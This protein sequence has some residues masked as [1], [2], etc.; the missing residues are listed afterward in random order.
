LLKG[1]QIGI[2]ATTLEANAA[3]RSIVRRDSGESYEEFLKGLAHE[4]GIDASHPLGL[5][6]MSGCGRKTSGVLSTVQALSD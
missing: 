3:M 1:K 2:D 6:A 4:S 5:I